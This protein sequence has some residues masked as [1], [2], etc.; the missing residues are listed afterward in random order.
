M[1]DWSKKEVLNRAE[2]KQQQLHEELNP[3]RTCMHQFFRLLKALVIFCALNMGIGQLL[4]VAFEVDNPVQYVLRVYVI[5]LCILVVLNELE[6]TKYTKD[7]TLLKLWIT[8]GFIYAFVG[9]LG[10]EENETS[11]TKGGSDIALSY[12]AIVAWM[13]VAAG[14]LYTILGLLC[15]QM[16]YDKLRR[17]Y[18]QRLERAKETA[19]TTELY[20]NDNNSGTP[21]DNVV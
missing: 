16:L 21:G 15:L 14:C 2:E 12:I 17:D 7:S 13:M 3:R 5:F 6:W 19:R 9:V 20:G 1:E 8:R 11:K 10:L 18:V 4:G